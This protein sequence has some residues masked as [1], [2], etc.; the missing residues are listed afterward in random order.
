MID[1]NIVIPTKI[2]FGK[3]KENEI[4][5]IVKEYGFSKILI[6]I[7]QGSVIRNGLLEKTCGLL[8]KEGINYEIFQGIRANPTI[9]KC[10][11]CLAFAREFAPE[12]ILAI[13]G[14]SVMDTAKNVACGYYY[15]GDSFDFNLHK[16]TPKKALPVGVIL[17][18]SASGSEMS[19][20]CVIQD[21]EL[22]I[23]N[24]FNSDLVRPL[25]A[26]ENPELTYTVNKVQTAYGIVD[27]IM[28]TFE[29]YM[30]PSGKV[31]P[32]DGFALTVLKSIVDVART[33]YNEPEDYDSRAILMLMSSL[34]HND[35][36]NIGKNK[37]MPLHALE[38][39][40]SGVYPQVAH[41]AGL[42]VIFRA[43]ARYYLKFD[44]DKFDLLGKNVFGLNE[45]D[46]SNNALKAIESFEK[47]FDDLDMP[48]NFKDLGIENPDIEKLVDV[49]SKDGTRT[50]G[51]HTKPIDRDVAR[52]LFTSCK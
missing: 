46:K 36:T 6:I 26:I 32:A 4:G 18:I 1:F 30:V 2:Y 43:W 24:G 5:K 47:L 31:E 40:V 7:G 38:H 29:R 23:K 48:R 12:M 25:F 19:S 20:S 17:T 52:E 42:A 35:L 13:G 22:N 14:G 45:L 34:S 33:A 10:R 51:H 11:E 49:F 44:I 39:V 15:D 28:H 41:A 3:G 9:D 37:I 27:M 16:V 21:D 50:V 8:E